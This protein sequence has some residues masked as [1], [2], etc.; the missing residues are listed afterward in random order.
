MNKKTFIVLFLILFLA[1]LL[2]FP[3]LSRFPS[4]FSADEAVQG[5]TAYSILKTG[6]DEWGQFLPLN[7]RSFGDYKPPLYTYLTIPSI[8]LFDLNEF[9]VRLPS[10]F[11]G[12]LAVL[13]VFLLTQ[14]L[15]GLVS[16]SLLSAFFLAVCPWHLVFS[17]SAIEANLT[18]FF[19]TMG[20]YFFLKGLKRT[21]F[22]PLAVLFLGLNLYT[23]H[24]ARLFTILFA[25]FLL[26]WFRKEIKFFDKKVL[27]SGILALIFI[28]PMVISLF[29]GGSKR[30]GDVS[31]LNPTDKW[32]EVS[33]RQQESLLKNPLPILA[34]NKFTWV[35]DKFVKNY[36]SYFSLSFLFTGGSSDS[37]YSN[38]PGRGLLHLWD[39]PFLMAAIWFF[40]KKKQ[41][42]GWLLLAWLLLAGLPASFSKEAA[43]A[44][45]ASPFL[46]LWSLLS[47]YGAFFLWKFLAPKL[48]FFAKRIILTVSLL[49]VC[50]S[51]ILFLDEYFSHAPVKTSRG[52]NYGY[53]QMIDYVGKIEGNYDKIILTKIFSEPQVF[54]AFYKKYDP[55]KYQNESQDFLRYEKD[56]FLFLDQLGIYHLGKYEF[57]DINWMA[58]KSLKRT[59][60][61]GGRQDFAM[62]LNLKPMQI[63]YFPDGEEAFLIVDPERN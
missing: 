7:P 56:G 41:K 60:I 52:L 28:L 33:S 29:A 36:F 32:Q 48:S 51:L 44:N 53:E 1:G 46:P 15:F 9:A 50:S 37:Y 43:H 3:Y 6:R 22:F 18:A 27:W 34:N 35:A 10:A 21:K 45:R 14:E 39:L 30:F 13:A 4:G 23:Y 11:W 61:V 19:F 49:L 54:F 59:L 55:L 57:R 58:D 63:I 25:A 47:A 38:L 31:L 17:R 8:A 5:Y 12:T 2:R 24:S 20:F 42:V 16:L 40:Y 26:F 62:D